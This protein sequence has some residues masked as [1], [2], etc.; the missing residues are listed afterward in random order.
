MLSPRTHRLRIIARVVAGAVAMY[1]IAWVSGFPRTYDDDEL[2]SDAQRK[3]AEPTHTPHHVEVDQIVVAI[4]THASDA[5][6]KVPRMLL[7]TNTIYHDTLVLLGDLEMDIGAF[8]VH[9][10]LDRFEM[11]FLSTQPDLERYRAQLEAARFSLDLR[12]LKELD[13]RKEVE[14][15]NKL[16]KYKYLRMLERAWELR[17]DRAWYVFVDMDTFLVRSNLMAW[18]GEYDAEDPIFFV[19]P[20]NAESPDPF[21]IGGTTFVLS[22]TA[23]RNFIAEREIISKWESSIADSASGIDILSSAITTELGIVSNMSWPAISGFNPYTIPYGPGLWCE[24]VVALHSVPPELATDIWRLQRDREE[25]QHIHDPLT[26]ADL[27]IRFLQHENLSQPRDE[28]DNLSSG[29]DNAKWN[30]LFERVEGDEEGKASRGEGS[31]EECRDSCNTNQHCVQ[32]SYSSIAMPNF[33]E[34]EETRC[35]LS[36]SMRLGRYVGSHR[37]GGGGGEGTWKSG[38]RKDKFEHWARNQ[39]CKT[40]Q[41]K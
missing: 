26:F 15:M 11:D 14:T 5:Y 27:W 16:D 36:S 9:D 25:Y 23:M 38:W 13:P 6:E 1:A 40:Q 7:L 34:N 32:F 8:H 10:V 41:N 33:N 30:I 24:E 28:W 4:N 2:P 12:S 39:R 17:P 20:P 21:G 3:K 31:W 29:S 18:L 35:H 19:N 37:I 22:H